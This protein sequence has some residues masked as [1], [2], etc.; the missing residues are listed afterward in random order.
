M[1]SVKVVSRIRPSN[2]FEQSL[3]FEE[4]VSPLN[5]NTVHIKTNDYTGNFV[6]D[7][8][9]GSKS[10]QEDLFSYSIKPT[11]DDLFQGYNGTVLAYGQTGSGKTYTMMGAEGDPNSS[12]LTPRMLQRIF[13]KIR[14]SPS[15]TEYEVKVSYMEIYMEKIRDLL[16]PDYNH[17]TVHE[18]KLQG[19]Y[20][21][22]LK[23]VY[24][25]SEAE[26]F[27]VLNQGMSSRAVAST[28][29]NATSSRSHSIF[30]VEV[31]QTNNSSGETRRGRLFLVDLA[32]SESVG[33][34]GAVGQTLEEAKK[35]N[36]SL[37]TLG[38]VINSLTENKH[39][40]IPYRDSKLTRILKESLGGNSRTTLIINCSPSL[41]N[42]SETLS[43]LRFGN[44][45]KNIKNKAVVNSELSMEEMKRKLYFYK[46]LLSHCDCNLFEKLKLSSK[47]DPSSLF[48][49]RENNPSLHDCLPPEDCLAATDSSNNFELE[50]DMVSKLT[51]SQSPDSPN[52]KTEAVEQLYAR[53]QTELKNRDGLLSST[54]Q[55]L[56]YLMEALG[57]AHERY[58]ELVKNQRSKQDTDSTSQLSSTFETQAGMQ[59]QNEDEINQER[60]LFLQKLSILDTSL[61]SLVYVQQRLIQT[62]SSNKRPRSGTVIKKIQGGH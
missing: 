44:R 27:Q 29:M 62:V 20:V 40:H 41:Y 48:V 58:V 18:N 42:A 9:F 46:A 49:Q 7:R 32:G 8:V 60:E 56:S 26:A 50:T 19:V 43:T 30:V 17:L 61:T 53:A 12:G 35:I 16:S 3:G 22:G 11:V 5:E 45:A 36:R 38:M 24:V 4:I 6:F 47:Q 25:S 1:T 39:G 54:R 13:D 31:V 14:S 28:N 15:T 59:K 23:T 10:T 33:K 55:Q 37:S 52:S 51:D 21:E 2:S 57:D 34:S